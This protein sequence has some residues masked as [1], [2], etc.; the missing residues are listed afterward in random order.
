MSNMEEIYKFEAETLRRVAKQCA[1][2][3]FK[4]GYKFDKEDRD[5]A[6]SLV[7][8]IKN[9][10]EQDTQYYNRWIDDTKEQLLRKVK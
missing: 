8:M 3:L 5:K 7:A 10:E 1:E 9:R 6:I 2:L 4:Y